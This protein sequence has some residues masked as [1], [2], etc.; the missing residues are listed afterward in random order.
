MYYMVIEGGVNLA[1]FSPADVTS[2][3]PNMKATGG[4][5][6]QYKGG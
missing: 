2:T 5:N 1:A 6:W 3:A 4:A